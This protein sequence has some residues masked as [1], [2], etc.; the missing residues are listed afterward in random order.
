MCKE[1]KVALQLGKGE[2]RFLMEIRKATFLVEIW[3]IFFSF[4]SY[5]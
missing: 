1:G 2:T 4:Q 3:V 5:Y